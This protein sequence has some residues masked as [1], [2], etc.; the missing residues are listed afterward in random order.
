MKYKIAQYVDYKSF[1]ANPIISL[2]QSLKF[3]DLLLIIWI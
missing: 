2:L 3:W 1:N